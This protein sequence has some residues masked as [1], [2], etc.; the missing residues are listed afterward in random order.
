MSSMPDGVAPDKT[1]QDFGPPDQ[2]GNSTLSPG[3]SD[4]ITNSGASDTYNLAQ[5]S[6]CMLSKGYAITL[7][8]FTTR[9]AAIAT[10]N[11]TY[12]NL[13]KELLLGGIMGEG[14]D[15]LFAAF[16][17]S[18]V[19]GVNYLGAILHGASIDKDVIV[20]LPALISK[21]SAASALYWCAMSAGITPAEINYIDVNVD[22][23]ITLEIDSPEVMT[24]APVPV[25]PPP[26]TPPA[27]PPPPLTPVERAGF[28][29]GLKVLLSFIAAGGLTAAI[30]I[31]AW[32]R[33]SYT[34]SSPPSPI[35]T[36]V[37]LPAGYPTNVP[38]GSYN[39]S[40]CTYGQCTNGGDFPAS[41]I[42]SSIGCVSSGDTTCVIRTQQSFNGTSFVVVATKTTTTPGA[43]PAENVT[44]WTVK[45][46]G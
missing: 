40:Y 8:S 28:S 10:M 38:N 27:P 29:L 36:Y 21:I 45:K 4:P 33:P 43:P 26:P 13:R 11:Q 20:D 5:L 37:D 39:I 35:S 42:A 7:N 24:P 22:K 14:L 9:D 19:V 12:V 30:A 15:E 1:W 25:V 31:G 16:K 32:P 44:T 3:A 6:K 46:V 2:G 41:S 17:A 34:P 23:P 18:S